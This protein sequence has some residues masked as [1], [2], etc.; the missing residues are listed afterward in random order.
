MKKIVIVDDHKLVSNAIRGMVEN[1][2]NCEVLYEVPHGQELLIRF[3]NKRNIPDLVLLDINM[4]IMDG[5]QT[6]KKLHKDYPD[7]RVLGLSMNDDEESYMKLIELGANG[8]ISKVADE[9]EL[10]LAIDTTMSNGYY[11]TETIANA[12][13]KSIHSKKKEES[14]LISEREKQLLS[15]ICTE[16]T[17][18]EIA[19]EMFLSPKTIDGYRNSLFQKLDIKSRV[20]LAMYAVKNGYFELE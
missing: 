18:Q 10:R 17:Y 16:K 3:E 11:Y 19:A 5:F 6:M 7:V 20:G 2:P 15:K 12:L 8:F 14:I 9:D 13:F 1:F 4:P